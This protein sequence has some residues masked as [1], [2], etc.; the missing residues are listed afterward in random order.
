MKKIFIAIGMII[1]LSGFG[2]KSN[3]PLKLDFGRSIDD[4]PFIKNGVCETKEDIITCFFNNEPPF[5]KDSDRNALKFYKGKLIGVNLS[6]FGGNDI[7]SV[8]DI[9][10]QK[11]KNIYPLVKDKKALLALVNNCKELEIIEYESL[12]E[13]KTFVFSEIENIEAKEGS[14]EIMYSHKPY[15]LYIYRSSDILD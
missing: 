2:F 4:I 15:Y 1:F 9:L 7:D 3:E 14:I 6:Y 12:S 11:M 10:A 8:C 13:N 5:E